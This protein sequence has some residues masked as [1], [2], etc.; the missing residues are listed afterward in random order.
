[1]L[2]GEGLAPPVSP[3]LITLYITPLVRHFTPV[4]FAFSPSQR[5]LAS[6]YSRFA[7]LFWVCGGTY[8]GT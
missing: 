6:I 5:L 8:F 2:L 4:S 3:C 7:M 1:M